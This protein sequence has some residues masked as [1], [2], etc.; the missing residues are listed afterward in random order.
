MAAFS[1]RWCFSNFQF[2]S[3]FIATER[4]YTVIGIMALTMHFAK[5]LENIN[6]CSNVYVT[7]HFKIFGVFYNW[8][9]QFEIG[10]PILKLSEVLHDLEGVVCLIDDILIYGKTQEE[11]DKHLTAAL[12]KI[13]EVGITL[14]EENKSVMSPKIKSHFLVR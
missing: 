7:T 12:H 3:L 11:H 6:H 9:T 4:F 2:S 13:A 8:P 5:V 10:Q 14:N 1:S